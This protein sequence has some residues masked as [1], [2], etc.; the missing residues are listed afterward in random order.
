M[1]VPSFLEVSQL[2]GLALNSC[3]LDRMHNPNIYNR[4]PI[5]ACHLD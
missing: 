5:K 1:S 3:L 4:K 2:F